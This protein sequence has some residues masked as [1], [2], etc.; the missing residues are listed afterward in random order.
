[1]IANEQETGKEKRRR[2]PLG[3]GELFSVGFFAWATLMMMADFA[4][5]K[6]LLLGY[7]RGV[8]PWFLNNLPWMGV[9][10]VL[11]CWIA[12]RRWLG[13][14]VPLLASTVF[15]GVSTSLDWRTMMAARFEIIELTRPM[16]SQET[17]MLESA[18]GDK[19]YL[20]G[21]IGQQDQLIIRRDPQVHERAARW[22]AEHGRKGT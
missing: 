5:V 21:S 19:V 12:L 2:R 22:L 10:F 16:E 17:G 7:P 3:I 9:G 20:K 4:A 11:V 18:I 6:P 15:M 13:G 14:W 1:M 8:A